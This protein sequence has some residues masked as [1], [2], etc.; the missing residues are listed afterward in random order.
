MDLFLRARKDVNHLVDELAIKCETAVYAKVHRHTVLMDKTTFVHESSTCRD[1]I[2]KIGIP[3]KSDFWVNLQI[4]GKTTSKVRSVILSEYMNPLNTW[5]CHVSM[6][7]TLITL[8]D[9]SC[10]PCE[11]AVQIY[12]VSFQLLTDGPRRESPLGVN[13]AEI[14]TTRYADVDE[15]LRHSVLLDECDESATRIHRDACHPLNP[16]RSLP[17]NH[18]EQHFLAR[19]A[20][21]SVGTEPARE[22]LKKHI[23]SSLPS[24]CRWKSEPVL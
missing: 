7:P 24:L 5:L 22:R 13:L 1:D 10:Q 3:P 4:H 16:S 19:C 21:Q 17:F 9:L 23:S 15:E 11:R 8:L 12:S 2:P 6:N 14:L 18:L 20:H